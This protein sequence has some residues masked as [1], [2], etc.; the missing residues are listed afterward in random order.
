M[1]NLFLVSILNFGLII[2]SGV[3]LF[4]SVKRNSVR[5]KFIQPVP[6]WIPSVCMIGGMITLF[7]PN[8]YS[9]NLIAQMPMMLQIAALVGLMIRTGNDAQSNNSHLKTW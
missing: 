2:F 3:V 8:Y 1:G 5:I 9:Y 7:S 4:A 6:V